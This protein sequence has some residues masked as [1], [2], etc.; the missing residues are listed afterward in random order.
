MTVL[1]SPKRLWRDARTYSAPFGRT[2][3]GLV[4]AG[5]TLHLHIPKH[6]AGGLLVLTLASYLIFVKTTA[7]RRSALR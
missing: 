6:Y 2:L 7:G 4:I 5:V 1:L 3:V